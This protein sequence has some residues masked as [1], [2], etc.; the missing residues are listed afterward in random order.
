MTNP[1]L[2]IVMVAYRSEADLPDVLEGLKTMSS[3]PHELHFHDNIGN[4]KTLTMA[5]NELASRGRADYI[6]FLN[7]DIRLSPE[8][9][10]RLVAGIERNIDSGAVLPKPVGHEW[11]RLSADPIQTTYA[12]P[13]T[14]PAPTHDAMR[15]LAEAWAGREAD[16]SFGG[17]CNAA[18]YAVMIRRSVW[19]ALKG[20]DERYRFY[21]QDHDFQRRLLS[22]FGKYAITID[23]APVWHRCG[24]SVQ[25]AAERGEVDFNEEMRHCG[26]VDA[27][28]KRGSMLEWDL[29]SDGDRL[30]IHTNVKYNRMPTH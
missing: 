30:R 5:W 19:D 24:G 20:F 28:L 26:A 3:L 21:G 25:K 15:R 12:D 18:F 29:L 11:R 27:A 6:V 13:A 23:S 4:T 2:D 1:S 17:G 8:W 7:T 10:A 9:D 22:R 16:Y 14:A